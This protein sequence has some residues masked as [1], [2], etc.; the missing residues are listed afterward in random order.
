MKT[1]AIISLAGLLTALLGLIAYCVARDDEPVYQ[2]R[3]LSAWVQRAVLEGDGNAELVLVRAIRT[4]D[5]FARMR[6]ENELIH[7]V[8]TGLGTRNSPLWRPYTVVRTNLPAYIAGRIPEWREPK[9]VRASAARWISHRTMW[10]VE[11]V[12]PWNE[13]ASKTL[14]ERAAPVLYKLVRIDPDKNVRHIAL[15]A[16]G[17][18]GILSKDTLVL[19]FQVLTYPDYQDRTVAARWFRR[20]RCEAERVVPFLLKGLEDPAMK[21]EYAQAL[22]AYG[23]RARFV[24]EPLLSL[25]KTNDRAISSAA[26]WALS[27]IDLPAAGKAGFWR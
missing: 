9:Q 8:M 15:V 19:M 10:S 1:P 23:E 20:T 27:G 14:C 21:S 24:V 5:A 26:L 17:D 25:A 4:G 13:R 18:V 11:Q 16:L 2:G 7:R 22:G 6:V 12:A 3:K